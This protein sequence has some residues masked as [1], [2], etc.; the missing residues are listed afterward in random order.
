M[1]RQASKCREWEKDRRNRLNN[2]FSELSKKLPCYQPS[3]NISKIEILQKA[4]GYID[5]LDTQ[6]KDLLANNA[7]KAT[8]EKIKK[9]RD[10]IKKL[11]IRNEQLCNLLKDAGI[12]YPSECGLVKFKT[13][14]KWA[15][16]ITQDQAKALADKEAQKENNHS[17]T[18]KEKR[19]D[20][21]KKKNS[22]L[23]SVQKARVKRKEHKKLVQ[24][25]FRLNIAQSNLL[26]LVTTQSCFIITNTPKASQTGVTK[27]TTVL[28]DSRIL[29]TPLVASNIRPTG[30]VFV[31]NNNLLPTFIHQPALVP[32]PILA[33]NPVIVNTPLPR[34]ENIVPT[35]LTSSI[36]VNTTVTNSNTVPIKIDRTQ[37]V[38]V[39]NTTLVTANG[40]PTC[41]NV[42]TASNKNNQSV[43]SSLVSLPKITTTKTLLPL[44]PKAH[45][46]TTQANK[47][48]IPAL[49]ADYKKCLLRSIN[50]NTNVVS[51]V[52]TYLSKKKEESKC[53]G[54]QKVVIKQNVVLKN[55]NNNEKKGEIKK[56]QKN[57]LNET[58]VEQN[59]KLINHEE[60]ISP[61]SEKKIK[62]SDEKDDGNK[63]NPTTLTYSIV[64][65]CTTT[66]TSTS[67]LKEHGSQDLLTTPKIEPEK[68][69]ENKNEHKKAVNIAVDSL[70]SEQK[71]SGIEEH[72]E[73]LGQKCKV[74]EKQ[75]D[76]TETKSE[77]LVKQSKILEKQSEIVVKET[78]I[79][80]KESEILDKQSEIL[81]KQ[82][83]M[84]EKQAL[85]EKPSEITLQDT[86]TQKDVE[87]K[88][89]ELNDPLG[90]SELSNDI[91]ASLSHVATG[92]QNPESTSPT[93]AF[94]LAFPLVSSLNSLKVTEVIEDEAT[95]S[96]RETPT[97]LQIGTMDS[98]KTTQSQS[99]TL[100]P[101]LLNLDNFSFFPKEFYPSFDMINTNNSDNITSLNNNSDAINTS[102]SSQVSIVK[103]TSISSIQSNCTTTN[104]NNS[105][106]INKI[107]SSGI[108]IQSNPLP[109]MSTSSSSSSVN[110]KAINTTISSNLPQNNGNINNTKVISKKQ[111]FEV[112]KV[113]SSSQVYSVAKSVTTHSI[114]NISSIKVERTQKNEKFSNSHTMPSSV[115][116][117]PNINYDFS[118]NN[119][120]FS[121]EAAPQ[122]NSIVP[123]EKDKL[124]SDKKNSCFYPATTT[125]Y[126]LTNPTTNYCLPPVT[127]I[128]YSLPITTAPYVTVTTTSYSLPV[129]TT[130]SQYNTFNPFT[131]LPLTKSSS[132][133][134]S[135]TSK[136][137]NDMLNTTNT[138]SYSYGDNLNTTTFS[139]TNSKCGKDKNYYSFNYD[140][141]E[142]KE[143]S[144]PYEPVRN[145]YNQPYCYNNTQ[146]NQQMKE[147]SVKPSS[148]TNN[149]SSSNTRPPVNWMTT[150][151][152]RQQSQDFIPFSKEMDFTP[153]T[154]YPSFSSV[155]Q[156]SYFNNN[157]YTNTLANEF[158][159]SFPET[160]KIDS[161]S[162][163]P[164]TFQ[165]TDEENQFSW[166]PSK[167]PHM[168]DPPHG[169]MSNT[170]PTLVGD[171]ALGNQPL[172]PEQKDKSRTKDVKRN[173]L[174]NSF[175][176][177][178]NFLSVSQL[179]DHSKTNDGNSNRIPNRRS[180]GSG[181]RN[182]S[183]KNSKSAKRST[184]NE[185]NTKDVQSYNKLSS[186]ETKIKHQSQSN[187]FNSN[188]N[189]NNGNNEWNP[190]GSNNNNNKNRNVKNPSSSYS[191]EALIGHQN[192]DIRQRNQQ[193]SYN[194][195]V[196]KSLPVP[197]LAENLLPYFPPVD[198]QQE[199]NLLP[200]NQ[201]F[202]H[203]L[204]QSSTFGHNFTATIQNNVYSNNSFVPTN[205]NLPDIGNTTDY[206]AGII[207][208]TFGHVVPKPPPERFNKSKNT[209]E[210]R[211]VQSN[212]S[213]SLNQL[214]T[215]K[216]SNKKKTVEP[217]LPGLVDFSFLPMP[218]AINSPIL[219]D[220]FHSHTNFLP[221]PPTPTQ[222]YPCKNPLYTKPT[223][224]LSHNLLPLPPVTRPGVPHPEISPSLNSVGS[225]LTN[226]NL[227]TIFP[228]INKG[229]NILDNMYPD[230]NKS[231][232]YS[233]HRDF[234]GTSQV[235][236]S[237]SN[238]TMSYIHLTS[239]NNTN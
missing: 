61:P 137:Y 12:R 41:L 184:K 173:K 156:S 105:G 99:D 108:S 196:N 227:S 200:Q 174:Q 64:S 58:D 225:S 198:I 209:E 154:V 161:F 22:S 20:K 166:S 90:H 202:G 153:G 34:A 69:S 206:N 178:Q 101:S 167:L 177:T 71:E 79:L 95:E 213:C 86:L 9:L 219:P 228:E 97:L 6:V 187:D 82:P 38:P 63:K 57:R 96:Q 232:E 55:K 112:A 2:S 7:P 39:S 13:P 85:L 163:M 5:E 10:Q 56:N 127:T 46:C 106:V 103:K 30:T 217:T 168:L 162:S 159:S 204:N 181:S 91:F 70:H 126:S 223:S 222:L 89:P 115:N 8:C 87:F 76:I 47:V 19:S 31:A 170:L 4:A 139:A 152:V 141:Y 216:K 234:L 80:D 226:F 133:T 224:D 45:T 18:I 129:V 229:S 131:D 54:P 92:G 73:I 149:T 14:K 16:K 238:P 140:N 132:Y 208:N 230:A 211:I 110:G 136:S 111:E 233:S 52:K 33:T 51:G 179:V 40:T 21:L 147:K 15:N 176:S 77:I 203:N 169:F 195:I 210:K 239:T 94:L 237:K 192:N 124:I 188:Q 189:N 146:P 160:R 182:N 121:S 120:F 3:L 88:V 119:S 172:F 17:N 29:S 171:L 74:L 150:P 148:N 157:S 81:E 197:F 23:K 220:D 24:S 143:F 49:S 151:D 231:K 145:Q 142:Y 118:Y 107:S 50:L 214:S 116:Y 199:N 98:T 72:P 32:T 42:K 11:L 194:P 37:K 100:T 193:S 185:N 62:L 102:S 48:P 134:S 65:L 125:S 78:E 122:T 207:D 75:P 104:S 212:N 28:T 180:S 215:S 60:D 183:N 26:S 191:A 205:F 135:I 164:N 53:R 155:T 144:K 221:P 59:K 44:R 27:T 117:P 236:F 68:L 190:L 175:D 113:T 165:R 83:D 201:T 1:P 128:S 43:S 158:T 84:L 25:A 130:I 66:L 218:A 114:S 36:L 123:N 109:I 138:Y 235:P 67:I 93:A 186:A 35:I